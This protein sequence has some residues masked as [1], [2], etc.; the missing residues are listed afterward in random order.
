MAKSKPELL[1]RTK[2]VIGQPKSVLHALA[3]GEPCTAALQ[4]LTA[5]RGA[6]NGLL[7]ELLED[8]LRHQLPHNSESSG[9]AATMSY[10]SCA[11]T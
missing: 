3:P 1:N 9:E 8:H 10:K 7:A 4:R 5:A 2:K 11:A 6:S